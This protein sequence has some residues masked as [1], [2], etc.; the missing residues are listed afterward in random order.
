MAYTI[1]PDKTERVHALKASARD[2]RRAEADVWRRALVACALAAAVWAGFAPL[3]DPDLPMHLAIGEW[4]ARHAA[5]PY[6]EPFAWTRP[7]APYFAYSWLAQISFYEAL[8]IAGP[9]GLHLLASVTG[10][11]TVLAGGAAGR[12]LGARGPATTLFGAL[13]AVVAIEST[14]FLRPQL[15]MFVLLPLAWACAAHLAAD[16]RASRRAAFGLCMVSALAANVHITFPVTAAVLAIPVL[17]VRRGATMPLVLGVAAVAL[18][19]ICS[20]YGTM[21]LDVFRLNFGE[22]TITAGRSPA[23]ELAP[24][25]LVA[26]LIGIALASLP[27]LSRADAMAWF[28]RAVYGA[29]WLAGLVVFARYFKG[30][31]PWWWCSLPLAVA[32]LR[33]VPPPSS[34]AVA[35]AFAALVPG[36]LA[37]CS[38]T[39]VRLYGVL[40]GYEGDLSSRTLPSI[41]AFA[42]EPAARWLSDNLQPGFHGRLLTSFNYGS[43]LKWRLPGISESIDTRGVFPDSAAL[44]D[45]PSLR[46]RA[47]LGPWATADVAIVPVS[48][49]VAEVLNRTPG[50]HHV[51]D[52]APSSWA[53]AS[54][55]VGLWVRRGWFEQQA[56]AGVS[57]GPPLT[58]R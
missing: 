50:W 28:E 27:L 44:P 58:L 40:R 29:L 7:G 25:F 46:A 33:R 12:A 53:P 20:P 55:P 48:F 22:N 19:W 6:V 3:A 51:G 10:A 21:W 17:R 5:V 47:H 23:G 54:S 36:M 8:R 43:Y 24:G 35:T 41:K 30:L 9:V 52:C 31:G 16:D 56:R 37:A 42:S 4:I 2:R 11:A 38:I 45:V 49:P 13:N 57:L 34:K 15:F 39:N 26:P 1:T 18:G 14:P 32:A